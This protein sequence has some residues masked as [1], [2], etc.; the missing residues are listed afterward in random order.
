MSRG[1]TVLAEPGREDNTKARE[2]YSRVPNPVS[3][4]LW[5]GWK[6][7][8][9]Y[10]PQPS[11]KMENAPRKGTLCSSRQRARRH[12][13][14][15]SPGNFRKKWTPGQA[16]DGKVEREEEHHNGITGLLSLSF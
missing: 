2:R 11:G 3:L 1:K 5:L 10:A 8:I 9:S 13:H 4:A 15:G 6:T 16:S 7:D 14:G 12:S